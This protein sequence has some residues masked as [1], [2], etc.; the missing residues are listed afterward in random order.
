M[1]ENLITTVEIKPD[2]ELEKL[3]DR[4]HGL[5]ET[6]KGIVIR[7]LTLEPGD[8]IVFESAER[9]SEQTYETLLRHAR[10]VW[11]NNKAAVIDRGIRIAGVTR[12]TPE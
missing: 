6:F 5:V 9:V 12:E 10:L 11:P 7:V 8:V 1:P 4:L 3:V 2:P